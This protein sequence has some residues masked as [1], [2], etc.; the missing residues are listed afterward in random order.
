VPP[1][2]TLYVIW[3]LTDECAGATEYGNR[4]QAGVPNITH[5]IEKAV[6]AKTKK[7]K[8]IRKHHNGKK[9]EPR[10]GKGKGAKCVNYLI[11]LY[12]YFG[13]VG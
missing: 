9:K 3:A 11:E 5:G 13:I 4:Q 7:C 1:E 6:R 10:G 8:C 2:T 12:S